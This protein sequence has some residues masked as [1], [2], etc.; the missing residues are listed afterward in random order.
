MARYDYADPKSKLKDIMRPR[1]ATSRAQAPKVPFG[2]RVG[3]AAGRFVKSPVGKFAAK[4][5]FPL[6]LA[7]SASSEVAPE[8][9]LFPRFG[10]VAGISEK[11][12]QKA[13]EEG[14]V[15][16][17]LKE[18]GSAVFPAVGGIMRD[19][20]DYAGNLFGGGEVGEAKLAE[21][22]ATQPSVTPQARQVQPA[23]LPVEQVQPSQNYFIR[24]AG[25][26]VSPLGEKQVLPASVPRQ[27]L[28]TLPQRP[29]AG[30]FIDTQSPEYRSPMAEAV[31]NL[32]LPR[33]DASRDSY[34][35]LMGK[36]LQMLNQ[37]ASLLP[38]RA[39][40]AEM[41]EQQRRGEVDRD[42][43]LET[44]EFDRGTALKEA[45]L[46]RSFTQMGETRRRTDLD[47]LA[48]MRGQDMRLKGAKSA[49]PL[50]YKEQVENQEYLGT[51]TANMFSDAPEEF[52]NIVPALVQQS[53]QSPEQV[54]DIYQ[55]ITAI[56]EENYPGEKLGAVELRD[57]MMKQLRIAR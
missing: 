42:F 15:L 1:V 16:P 26:G 49:Q 10:E 36:R 45:D 2:E 46:A 32:N 9:K 24:T 14:G 19:V 35:D 7:Q 52:A 18:V 28:A 37:G 6:A 53:G 12:A 20:G 27:D 5:A 30:D 48:T 39:Q 41:A 23:Q 17:A 57:E 11:R 38:A 55:R 56:Q 4:A 47:R 51:L 54:L 29:Q 25:K 13:Y 40:T 33:F 50:T 22:P 8:S 21:E 44:L 31:G 34:G 43:G 3:T